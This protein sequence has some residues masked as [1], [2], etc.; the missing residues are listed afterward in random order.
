MTSAKL[1]LP[2]RIT[3]TGFRAYMGIIG[4]HYSRYIYMLPFFCLFG[5]DAGWCNCWISTGQMSQII[6]KN[7]F[8]SLL[9]SFND[10]ASFPFLSYL[11][12]I[13]NVGENIYL[14]ILYIFKF[15]DSSP[16][17]HNEINIMSKFLAWVPLVSSHLLFHLSSVV[18]QDL[19]KGWEKWFKD[20]LQPVC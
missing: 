17:S 20:L 15:L 10:E 12:L 4:A 19:S 5:V 6:C 1:L 14:Y 2:Y 11:P 16:F 8:K 13:L 7:L 3:F 9:M 18:W